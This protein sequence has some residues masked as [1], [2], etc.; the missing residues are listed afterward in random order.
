MPKSKDQIRTELAAAL[1]DQT[2]NALVE[3]LTEANYR[4]GELEEKLQ[5]ETKPSN[6]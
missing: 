3:A 4:I 2:I 1:R 5:T 6:P